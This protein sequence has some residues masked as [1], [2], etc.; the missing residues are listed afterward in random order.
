MIKRVIETRSSTQRHQYTESL[1]SILPN[2][3]MSADRP[4]ALHVS[5]LSP[6]EYSSYTAVLAEL[7]GPG[8][9]DNPWERPVD[10]AEARG[11][12]RGRYGLDA[13]IV[14]KVRLPIACVVDPWPHV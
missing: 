8:Q 14:D 9:D 3:H 5:A 4:L 12:I 11:W 13:S 10:V 2:R 7:A 6:D 1:S